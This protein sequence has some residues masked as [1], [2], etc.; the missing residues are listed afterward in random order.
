MN[1][2]KPVALLLVALL[3]FELQAQAPVARFIYEDAEAAYEQRDYALALTRLNEA[4]KA[5]GK[6]NAPILY[7]RILARHELLKA[8]G[9]GPVDFDLLD[10]LRSDV[11]RYFKDY[12]DM[13][14][15]VNE[16]R[17]VY[18]ISRELERYPADRAVHEAALAAER[19]A[20][21]LER[22]AQEQAREAAE[23]A[24]VAELARLSKAGRVFRDCPECPE[25]IVVPGGSLTVQAH[26]GP[27]DIEI[28]PFALARY[29]LTKEQWYALLGES[30]PSHPC[31]NCPMEERRYSP[32]GPVGGESQDV[33]RLFAALRK[34]TGHSYYLP[35]ETQWEW[36]CR[37]G[38]QH[39]YCGGEA[40]EEVA[41][42][43]KGW[44]GAQP[45][46]IKKPNG[47]GLY[48]MSGNAYDG[49]GDSWFE[50][51][52]PHP[53]GGPRFSSDSKNTRVTARGGRALMGNPKH[54]EAT[55]RGTQPIGVRLARALQGG[56]LGVTFKIE[57]VSGTPGGSSVSEIRAGSAAERA[58]LQ[59]GD[60]IVEM[61][62]RPI[63]SAYSALAYL[64]TLEAGH[65]V[66]ITYSRNGQTLS[67]EAVLDWPPEG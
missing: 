31:T 33:W 52:D 22:R 29:E 23:A 43:D 56:Q 34:K 27:R 45:V 48:D 4:E 58:G 59:V 26:D 44:T 37:G 25:M 41:W 5:F 40:L 61:N 28:R 65:T 47:Y 12:G 19:H 6:T 35:S 13:M 38:E 32:H 21:E 63:L 2:L 9:G 54:F 60:V 7:L 30:L 66:A 17:E 24:R 14:A 46:G 57:P 62:N 64:A 55:A 20:R 10:P 49:T 3:S 1:L 51:Y 67:S 8:K 16:M 53:D 39:R 36:A 15:L 11:Q 50:K 42:F 18:L